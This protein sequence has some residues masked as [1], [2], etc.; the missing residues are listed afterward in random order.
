MHPSFM[1]VFLIFTFETTFERQIQYDPIQREK[2]GILFYIRSPWR[3]AVGE[4]N[5]LWL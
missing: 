2:Q 3:H 4:V 1:K 5:A